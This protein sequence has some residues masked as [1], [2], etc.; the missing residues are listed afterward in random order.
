[1]EIILITG[2]SCAGKQTTTAIM[3]RFLKNSVA[4][5][6]DVYIRPG[7]VHLASQFKEIFG[8]PV[9]SG[10]SESIPNPPYI[11]FEHDPSIALCQVETDPQTT[12]EQ[13]MKLFHL[14]AQYTEKQ[15][16]SDIETAREQG[17][18]FVIVEYVML[19]I[20]DIWKRANYRVMISSNK[21]ARIKHLGARFERKGY[22]CE[23]AQKSYE[24]RQAVFGPMLDSATSVDCYITNNYDENYERDL[25]H[26][27]LALQS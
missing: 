8:I 2:H 16:E 13:Y 23:V 14:L 15:I 3:S 20:L 10:K 12:S 22:S 11:H 19:P 26:M 17:K 9:T 1:M 25:R 24:L 5:H 4:I 6:A 7:L 27:C 21:Q 18:D